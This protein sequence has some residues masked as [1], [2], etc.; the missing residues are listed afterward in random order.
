MVGCGGHASGSWDGSGE[1]CKG[2][3]ETD[4][5]PGTRQP[6]LSASIPIST[7]DTRGQGAEG[8]ARGQGAEGVRTQMVSDSGFP[9]ACGVVAMD[10]T[11][12]RA[13]TVVVA[14]GA[15][16]TPALLMRS[17]IGW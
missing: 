15:L 9:R 6:A 5:V 8:D 10:G 13:N 17:G 12:Y 16:E 2:E 4:R 1:G 7:G 14:G 11:V 3:G